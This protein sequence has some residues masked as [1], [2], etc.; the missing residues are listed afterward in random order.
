MREDI[1][2]ELMFEVMGSE[3][4]LYMEF[5]NQKEAMLRKEKILIELADIIRNVQELDEDDE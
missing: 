2:K 3:I 4:D 5:K 1:M